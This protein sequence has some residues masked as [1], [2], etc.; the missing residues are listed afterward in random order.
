MHLYKTANAELLSASGVVKLVALLDPALVDSDVCELTELSVLKL[1]GQDY[2][3]QVLV[4]GK[5]YFTFILVQIQSIVVYV[6]RTGQ[7]VYNC[8]QQRLD[9]LVLVGRTHEN[10]A[11][12]K[13]NGFLSDDLFDQV[14]RNFVHQHGLHQLFAVHGDCIQHFLP[15]CL[16]FIKEVCRN[17]SDSQT[18]VVVAGVKVVGL[19]LNKVYNTLELVFKAYWDLHEN[20]IQAELF[21]Q[22]ILY[23]VGIGATSVALVYESDAGNMVPLHLAVDSNGLGLYTTNRAE[24]QDGAIKNTKGTLNFDCEVNVARS[25]DDVDLMVF[26]ANVGCSGSNCDTTLSLKFHGV[27]CSSDSILAT[28][29]VNCVNLVAVVKNTLT[30][31]GLARV[32]MSAYTNISHIFEVDNHIS[33]LSK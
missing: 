9:A 11:Q 26:P 5:L 6:G 17:L 33:F 2:R 1:E 12:A 30:E 8:V 14:Y 10:G 27:H 19:H 31:C 18:K 22:L 15:L 25:I 7:I 21:D 23:T 28:D 32:D 16:C 3:R 13:R 24:N 29:I 20:C 4:A